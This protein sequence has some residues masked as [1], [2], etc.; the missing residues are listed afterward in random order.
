MDGYPSV[1]QPLT[2]TASRNE[3]HRGK[4]GPGSAEYRLR[5]SRALLLRTMYYATRMTFRQI[6]PSRVN[7]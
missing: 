2:Y 4:A 1:H 5:V 7:F 6:F 3:S